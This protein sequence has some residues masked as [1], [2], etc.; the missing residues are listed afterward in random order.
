MSALTLATWNVNSLRQRLDGLARL[1]EEKG[2][3]VLC[4]Q[5]TKVR[6][7]EFPAE[8]IKA[9]GFTHQVIIGQK[10][11]NGVAVL[12]RRPFKAVGERRAWWGKDDCRHASV[13]LD[14]GLEIHNFY[15]P[16]GG[17]TPDPEKNEKFA[18]K[19][20]FYDEMAQWAADRKNDDR[21][22]ILV[23]DLNIAPWENDVW[24]HK[25]LLRSVGHTPTE[26]ERFQQLLAS[27][28]LTDVGRRFVPED[29]P[30]YS[31]WGYRFAQSFEKD[32][33]WRLDHVLANAAG[34][35][36]IAGY[37]V[38]RDTRTWEKPSDHV[39]VIVKVA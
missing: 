28:A 33:G 5:E 31:W 25:K 37:E 6:D 14:G 34:N 10:S 19:L 4:L 21:P 27:G 17:P 13:E 23:G 29:K 16:S 7:E 35:A 22:M 30:L 18:H 20:G 9:M 2:P 26:T 12:S 39:P 8:E 3:D 38:F 1:V 24:N 15:A 36:A 11:Y 32:Y